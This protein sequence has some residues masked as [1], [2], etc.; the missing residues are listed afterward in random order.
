MSHRPRPTPGTCNNI[1]PS[2]FRRV[3]LS[4]MAKRSRHEQARQARASLRRNVTYAQ[5]LERS[6]SAVSNGAHGILL[7]FLLGQYVLLDALS[8]DALLLQVYPTYA[9]PVASTLYVLLAIV[10]L[11]AYSKIVDRGY[12]LHRWLTLT[13]FAGGAGECDGALLEHG[14]LSTPAHT[15]APFSPQA[16]S[17]RWSSMSPCSDHQYK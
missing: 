17:S 10:L 7:G 12:D 11:S 9:A 3:R 14:P 8:D 6:V 13:A 16:I 4:E 5:A 15:A 2:G 1:G